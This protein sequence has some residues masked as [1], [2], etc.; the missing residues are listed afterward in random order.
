MEPINQL[1][2][3]RPLLDM[4]KETQATL[5]LLNSGMLG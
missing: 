2:Q 3:P 1:Y 5:L 4:K